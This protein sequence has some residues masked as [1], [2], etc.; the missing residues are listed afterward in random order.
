MRVRIPLL[1]FV[2]IVSILVIPSGCHNNDN[3]MTGPNPTV[4]PTSP[5]VT[6]T[7]TVPPATA[8]PATATPTRAAGTATPTPTSIAVGYAGNWTGQWNNTTFGTSGMATLVDTVNTV[9]QTFDATFTL[10]GNVFGA[11]APPPPMHFSGS[12]A[13]GSFHQNATPIGDI[14][15]N[16]PSPGTFVGSLQNVPNPNIARVDFM[17]TATTSQ[18]NM[19]YTIT[20]TATAGG[21]SANGTM[22]LNHVS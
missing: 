6:P 7:A 1:L 20:F 21:G 3:N 4:T 13:S 16:F 14:T 5:P 2:C 22:V 11:P 9:A 17:G 18:I 8:P 19:I 12:Y 10:F 15:I